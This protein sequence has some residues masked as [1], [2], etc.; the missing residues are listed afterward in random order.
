MEIFCIVDEF[1]SHLSCSSSGILIYLFDMLVL[2]TIIILNFTQIE[3]FNTQLYGVQMTLTYNA[4]G[5]TQ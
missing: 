5:L 1:F 4:Q 3:T 2:T